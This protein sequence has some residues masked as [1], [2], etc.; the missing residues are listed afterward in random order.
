ME[1]KIERLPTEL[2]L[3]ILELVIGRESPPERFCLVSRRWYQSVV[4]CASFWRYIDITL[5]CYRRVNPATGLVPSIRRHVIKS[6]PCRLDVTIDYGTG[7]RW[8][9]QFS[10]A[11]RECAGLNGEGVR[12]WSTLKFNAT[13]NTPSQILDFFQHP[14]PALREL[15]ICAT[16]GLDMAP[17]FPN[18]PLLRVLHVPSMQHTITWPPAFRRLVSTLHVNNS[19]SSGFSDLLRNFPSIRS[20]HLGSTVFMT[21]AGQTETIDLLQ[22]REL[23][24][25]V[26][27]FP[28]R[29]PSLYL[30][31]MTH[32]TLTCRP[33]RCLNPYVVTDICESY[34]SILAK[35]ENLT[36]LRLGCSTADDL[37]RLLSHSPHVRTL[38]MQACGRW[39]DKDDSRWL[40]EPVL[41]E[42]FYSVLE[43]KELCPQLSHCS[44]NGVD[45]SDLVELRKRHTF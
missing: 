13:H 15:S 2:L 30:P 16:M 44:L 31:C 38:E 25:S 9:N 11:V 45:R 35:I 36:I 21:G 42:E 8:H 22:L 6:Y 32:L 14:T 40:R 26:P 3:C 19:Q 20:L 24:A 34:A 39:V 29:L 41:V 28:F 4:T 43:S 23:H 7:R 33:R 27:D 10:G 12:R 18:A 37:V 17:L 1:A 5:E